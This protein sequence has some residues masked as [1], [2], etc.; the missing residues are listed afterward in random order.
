MNFRLT[1]LLHEGKQII[2]ELLTF[3]VVTEFIQLKED[4]KYIK[5]A[6]IVYY[7]RDIIGPLS[8]VIMSC[9]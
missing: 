7:V 5:K 1:S 3:R 2:E 4:E 8:V 6:L 9:R